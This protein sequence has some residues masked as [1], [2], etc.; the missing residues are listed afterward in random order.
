MATSSRI[1]V[2]IYFS[3]DLNLAARPLVL[4]NESTDILGTLRQ[5]V[6][7]IH[8]ICWDVRGFSILSTLRRVPAW[9][10]ILLE[11]SHFIHLT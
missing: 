5:K 8:Y 4:D 10:P 7:V 3:A 2:P 9:R 1:C 6:V 11:S